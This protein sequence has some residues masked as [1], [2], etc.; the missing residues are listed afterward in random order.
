MEI[1]VTESRQKELQPDYNFHNYAT[2]GKRMEEGINIMIDVRGKERR[3]RG[4]M[5]KVGE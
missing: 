2:E 3:G 1:C 5:G 4:I